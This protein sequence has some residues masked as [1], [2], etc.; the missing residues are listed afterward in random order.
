[1]V[2]HC[3]VVPRRHPAV[4]YLYGASPEITAT[5]GLS[6]KHSLAINVSANGCL[7]RGEGGPNNPT[8]GFNI[9]GGVEL[10]PPPETP[11]LLWLPGGRE[12]PIDINVDE[13]Y[14]YCDDYDCDHWERR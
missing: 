14:E 6:L 7:C 9:R 11:G 1:M 10:P 8:S 2:T 3:D 12:S 13:R 4:P 5:S